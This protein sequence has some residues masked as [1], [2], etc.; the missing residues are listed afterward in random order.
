MKIGRREF[1]ATLA[2]TGG[3]MLAGCAGGPAAPGEVGGKRRVIDAHS[4]WYPQE[5]VALVQQE[6]SAHGGKV[7]RN[8][9][10]SVTFTRNQEDFP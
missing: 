8:A 10:G 4:H 6:G 9:S 3:A 2:A 7:G 1:L 5:F